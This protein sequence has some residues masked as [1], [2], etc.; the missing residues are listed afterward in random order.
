MHFNLVILPLVDEG[1]EKIKR[2][3]IVQARKS[4]INDPGY[5]NGWYGYPPYMKMISKVQGQKREYKGAALQ[6]KY[7]PDRLLRP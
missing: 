6:S 5:K 3:P 7:R 2:L 1:V 4:G